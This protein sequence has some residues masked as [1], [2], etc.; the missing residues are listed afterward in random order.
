VLATAPILAISRNIYYPVKYFTFPT[1][2]HLL[3]PDIVKL[4]LTV[5]PVHKPA[6]ISDLILPGS[7]I[8]LPFIRA[9]KYIPAGPVAIIRGPL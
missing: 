1:G 3:I 8:I 6:K 2:F 9:V 7:T 5:G 4:S